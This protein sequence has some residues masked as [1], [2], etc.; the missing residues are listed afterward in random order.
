MDLSTMADDRA[1]RVRRLASAFSESGIGSSAALQA[2]LVTLYRRDP[3]G[4][5]HVQRVALQAIKLGEALG[6][7][8]R[9][10][11]DLERAAWLHDVGR[12]AVP[13]LPISEGHALDPFLEG[14]RGDQ[15]QAVHT[16]TRGTPFLH[17]AADLVVASREYFDGTGVP[18][19]LRGSDIPIGA[20]ALHV[21][22]VVDALTSLSLAMSRTTEP[23]VN[24][25]LVRCSGSRFDP[26]VVAAW[27]RCS[28]DAPVGL[29]PWLAS[30]ERRE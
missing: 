12:I 23:V 25:E 21:A 10:L 29:I 9:D 16:V 2:L 14:R 13:G 4:L 11:D 22:D 6:I 15:V 8:G 24:G 3:E 7:A 17:A 30:R 27:L 1:E 20:R 18:N 28:D 5:A 26:S 19:G